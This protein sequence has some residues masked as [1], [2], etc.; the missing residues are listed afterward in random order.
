M[1]P[2]AAKYPVT[3]G[4]RQ[5]ARFDPSY[6]HRGVDYGCP[7]GTPVVA[8]TAGTVVHAGRGG[9]GPAFGIHVVLKTGAT[10]H[11]Y[12]HLSSE[13]VS[14]GAEDR[15]G[16]ACREVRR[17]RQR[18]RQPSALRRVHGVPLQIRP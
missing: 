15:G 3:L 18:H 8:A 10:F 14:V 2:V 1:R 7:S 17:D 13:S 12:A 16:S 11:I 6:I 4:Y 9:M 5:K